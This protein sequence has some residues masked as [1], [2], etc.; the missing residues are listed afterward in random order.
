MIPNVWN[1]ELSPFPRE[2]LNPLNPSSACQVTMYLKAE[3]AKL[4]R[5]SQLDLPENLTLDDL[6]RFQQKLRKKIWEKLGVKYDGSLPLDIRIY[7]TV[8]CDTYCIRK[9]IYQSRPGIYATALLYVPYDAEKKKNTV[10]AVIHVHGH[11]PNGKINPE[12]QTTVS[13]LVKKGFVCLSVDAF[14]TFERACEHGVPEYHGNFIGSAMFNI[15]ET[16]MGAQ[17]VDNMRG[18]DLLESLPYVRKDKIGVTGASG[19][20]N[21]TM[22]LAAMDPRIA[23]AMPVVSVGSFESYVTGVNCVCELL[24]D[25]MTFTEEASVLALIAPRPLR[26]G[27]AFYDVNHTFSVAEML[28]T[29][30]QVEKIYQALG[31]SHCIAYSVTPEVHGYRK[32]QQE[33]LL[34]WFQWHLMGRGEGGTQAV[35]ELTVFPPHELQVFAKGEDRPTEVR[36]IDVH[37]R[38]VGEELRKKMLQTSSFSSQE[39]RRVLKKLL[40]LRSLPGQYDLISYSPR[41]GFDRYALAV[42][43]RLIPI[44]VKNG[45]RKGKYQ[46]VLHPEGKQQFTDDELLQY[47][48]NGETLVCIDLYGE[49]ETAQLNMINGYRHQLMRQLLWL[50]RSV[51]GEWVWDILAVIRVLRQKFKAETIQVTGLR[52]AGVCAAFAAALTPDERFSV[53]A[54]DAPA[55]LLFRRD[56][57]R[58]FVCDAFA[59]KHAGCLY[60]PMLSIPQFLNWG[61]ISLVCA[62]GDDRIR[63]VS[64]RAFDGTAYT[65]AEEKAFEEEIQLL[66]QR[67]N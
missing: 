52:E 36:S 62:L 16:L 22:Y 61:D 24:P 27:N 54:E 67:L 13:A 20:G 3:A 51:P 28:K 11:H 35:P 12:V 1:A 17:L 26:I 56:S 32:H 30:G 41:N 6:K 9:L 46:L 39:K 57:I 34:G 38:L 43:D 29:Y 21:Q 66:Q 10:P 47:Q 19:G 15:G 65:Q 45:S 5:L 31:C 8:E 7:D 53:V 59:E 23:V 58:T 48:K 37:C 63:F 64:P 50:G 4:A 40:R 2:E 55:S 42:G 18:I 49:G 44:L 60:S 33:A 14:G 25:G